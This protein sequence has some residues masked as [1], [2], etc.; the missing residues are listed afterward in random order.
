MD[1]ARWPAQVF[2]VRPPLPAVQSQVAR[3]PLVAIFRGRAT[4]AQTTQDGRNRA[5]RRRCRCEQQRAL[6][7]D[8][9]DG[10]LG[11]KGLA[12]RRPRHA[13][14]QGPGKAARGGTNST[15]ADGW[16][17][18]RRSPSSPPPSACRRARSSQL[19]FHRDRRRRP[20]P[21]SARADGWGQR[22]QR[23]PFSSCTRS[24][25]SMRNG[26]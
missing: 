4:A 6:L 14:H 3:S 12:E 26:F 24:E 7:D 18:W 1:L 19:R 9:G 11:F 5:F 20:A 13:Q 15:E 17:S 8:A 16:R 2:R 22:C 21:E 25:A 10:R 23:R